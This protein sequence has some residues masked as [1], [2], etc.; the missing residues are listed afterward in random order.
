MTYA[1]N[2]LPKYCLHKA[3]GRAFVRIEGKLYYLGKHGS[4]ASRQEYDRVIGEFVAGGRLGFDQSRVI[5]VET[6]IAKF[7]DNMERNLK[8]SKSYKTQSIMLFQ[9]LNDLYGKQPVTDFG[10]AAL[11]A[12][13]QRFVEQ[14]L[15]RGEDFTIGRCLDELSTTPIFISWGNT[16]P[17]N[18]LPARTEWQRWKDRTIQ[19][20]FKAIYLPPFLF[21]GDNGEVRR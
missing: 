9:Q 3:S 13:R 1:R 20:L 21:F 6:L 15:R 7:L 11:K 14:G 4:K 5:L 8:Y 17:A 16:T 12:L 19:S 2:Q 18:F 10:I